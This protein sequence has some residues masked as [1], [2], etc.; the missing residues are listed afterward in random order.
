MARIYIPV[1]SYIDIPDLKLWEIALSVRPPVKTDS[2]L[3]IYGSWR[4]YCLFFKTANLLEKIV[5]EDHVIGEDI[6]AE[7]N[8]AAPEHN[9]IE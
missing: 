3:S 6:L 2:S 7:P 4:D 1:S 9:I 8:H 5:L